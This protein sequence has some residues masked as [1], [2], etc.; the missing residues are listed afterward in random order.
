[1][2]SATL[3]MRVDSIA[4]GRQ[5]TRR[6]RY[7]SYA[8]ILIAVAWSIEVIV[9]KDTDWSRISLKSLLETARRFVDLD[10]GVIPELWKPALETVV[11]ATLATVVGL[12][13]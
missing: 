6:I 1:M 3:D 8:V 2:S 10:T 9:V 5:R 4:A 7:L 13:M 11:M 12:V